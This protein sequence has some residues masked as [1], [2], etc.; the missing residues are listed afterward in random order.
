MDYCFHINFRK[1]RI[2]IKV[3]EMP[4]E[5]VL[6]NEFVRD[7]IERRRINKMLISEKIFF[8]GPS[9]NF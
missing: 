6:A 4:D 7:E 8:W 3:P 1:N 5:V 9:K 2:N